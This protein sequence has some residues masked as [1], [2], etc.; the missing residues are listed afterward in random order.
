MS[1]NRKFKPDAPVESDDETKCSCGTADC[2]PGTSRR[3]FLQV[4]GLGL[5]SCSSLTGPVSV[6]A[7]PFTNNKGK[8]DI[9]HFVPADKKLSKEWLNSLFTRGVQEVYRGKDLDT[10]GMPVGGIGAGQLYLCGDGTLGC[11]QIFNQSHFTGT[12]RGLYDKYRTPDSPVDQGF[13]VVVDQNGKKS[14]RK[15][16][17]KDFPAVEFVGEYPI[18][19]VRYAD[20]KFPV[21]IEMEAFSPFIPLNAQ[22]SGLPATLFHVTVE[23]S[24]NQ[25]LRAG[26]LG[27][28]ENAVC[29]HSDKWVPALRRNR[30]VNQKGRALILHTAEPLPEDQRA[31]PRPAIVL[32]DFEGEDYGDWQVEGKAFGNKPAAGALENQTPVSGYL[33]KG[34]VNTYWGGDNSKGRLTSPKFEI[35]RRFINLLVGGGRHG[36]NLQVTLLVDGK[37]VRSAS[38][39]RREQLTWRTWN[40]MNYQG[41]Q[42]QIVIVDQQTGSW[43]H[44]N[45]DHIELSDECRER[46]LSFDDLEDNGSLVLGMSGE[47]APSEQIRQALTLLSMAG[48]EYVVDSDMLYSNTDKRK[49]AL[50]SCY[51]ELAPG[52]KHTF[53]FVLGWV[54]PNRKYI[55]D[56]LRSYPEHGTGHMYANWFTH[57]SDV[58]HYVLDNHDRLTGHTRKWRDTYYDSTLPYWLLN[59]LHSTVSYLATGTC[60]WWKN[61]RFWAWEGVGCCAGTCT[62]VWNYAH[63]SSRL[64]P[65][66]ERSVREMQ[67]LGEAFHPDGMVAF[68]GKVNNAYAADGQCGTVLKCYREHLMSADKNYLKR[69]W[70]K[71]RKVLEYAVEQDNNAD[72]LI[73]NSQHNTFDIN[74]FGPNTFVG[75]LYL[76]ALR[77]G[78]EMAGE[79]GD[80]DFARRVRKIYQ[81]GRRLS[82]ERLWNDEYFIQ[83]VDLKEHPQHQYGRGCLSDQLFG[84]GWARQLALGNIYPQS[85]VKKA[86]QSV[87]KYNWAPDVTAHN[88]AHKPGRWFISPG[89]AG[90][91]TCTWPKSPHLDKGVRYKNEVWTGIEY[92]VAGNMIWEGMLTEGLAIIRAIHDRYHPSKHNPYNEVECGD[93]YAR[94]LASWGCFTALAGY[95]YHGP[96]HYLAFSP[97]ISPENFRSAFTAAQGWGTFAQKQGGNSQVNTV[98][99]HW[100]QLHLKELALDL[101]NTEETPKVKTSVSGRACD[102]SHAYK[103]GRLILTFPHGVTLYQDETLEVIIG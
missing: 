86:L 72:G 70:P 103:N 16:N 11:W 60:M 59:R 24:S 100:G 36:A 90:L 47:N 80:Q 15:L 20:E 81:N 4:A 9:S 13:A 99:V 94:A 52:A 93:H 21:R 78:E 30:I 63:G 3:H 58:A 77:A 88:Q 76:A 66:L 96:K 91:F 53:T 43:G 39:Q 56:A 2:C 49:S 48:D 18:G 82:L 54:F 32:A 25:K 89:E 87:W 46:I 69:N 42:G 75:S 62:H 10:I 98:Q 79:V 6:M 64:F 65:A 44:I 35:N 22:D 37:A 85:H 101:D 84:Q 34:L 92:Q 40:V 67:D 95:Q 23:N 97:K 26:I 5:V 57:A 68:R 83:D 41:K 50:M 27:W 73:E 29:F 1:D 8:G 45:V 28:L 7:G 102:A 19:T 51:I 38:G 55:V 14:A 12:G 71:I 17:K 61:G 33:G 31:R 74:F